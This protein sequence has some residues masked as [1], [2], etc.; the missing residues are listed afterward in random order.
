[1]VTRK[2]SE[3]GDKR[4]M[5]RISKDINFFSEKKNWNNKKRSSKSVLFIAQ[6]KEKCIINAD[7]NKK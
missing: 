1:M 3:D 2:I 5:Q 4:E 7:R 6:A